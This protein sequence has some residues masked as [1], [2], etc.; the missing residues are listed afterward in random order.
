MSQAFIYNLAKNM[1]MSG[2]SDLFPMLLSLSFC[3]LCVLP[4]RPGEPRAVTSN[5]GLGEVVSFASI[6]KQ[7][8]VEERRACVRAYMNS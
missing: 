6:T 8:P 7:H 4:L 3:I 2:S 1:L 5:Q